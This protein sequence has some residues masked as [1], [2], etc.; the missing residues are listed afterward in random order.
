MINNQ[1]EFLKHFSADQ[2]YIIH[3]DLTFLGLY[4]LLLII[5]G[6]QSYCLIARRLFHTTYKLYLL[7]V[8]LELAGIAFLCTYYIIFALNGV[9]SQGNGFKAL[10]SIIFL[11]LL[12]LLS[13]GYTVTRARL[14]S[15]SA[16]TIAVFITIY[17]TI[18]ALLFV[19]EN[20]FFDPGE[21]LYTYESMFGY[22]LVVLRFIGLIAFTYFIYKTVRL[23]P[24]KKGFFIILYIM[25]CVWFISIPIVI[26]LATY[27]IPKYMREQVVNGFEL[28]VAF[29]A[30][31]FF[32]LITW[33]TKFN[34]IFPFHVRTNQIVAMA[35][36]GRAGDDTLDKFTHYQ[37]APKRP[38]TQ[39]SQIERQQINETPFNH[40]IPVPIQPSIVPIN[41]NYGCQYNNL[42]NT[43][44]RDNNLVQNN[45]GFYD[46][47]DRYIGFNLVKSLPEVG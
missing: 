18:Y 9:A 36:T 33:P 39:Q 32:M 37:Y 13:K 44:H 5:C 17:F 23:Y 31:I 10:S 40:E 14:K 1:S 20:L 42:Y 28:G 19:F 6:I 27:A 11:L 24:T 35:K 46:R 38:Q 45:G 41:H 8:V 47:N 2:Y 22:G 21:V 25:Y 43:A 30:H 15:F 12:I 7:A 34:K 26:L 3:T 29:R 4:I 16:A